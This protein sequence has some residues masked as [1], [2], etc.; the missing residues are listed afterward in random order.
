MSYLT[1]TTQDIQDVAKTLIYA[2]DKTTSRDIL[3]KMRADNYW[4]NQTEVA[5]ALRDLL[6]TDPSYVRTFQPDASVPTGGYFIYGL[7]SVI[8]T[9]ASAPVYPAK[10]KK[11]QTVGDYEARDK[12]DPNWTLVRYD[13]V[14]ENQAKHLFSEEY[15][16]AYTDVRVKKA[17]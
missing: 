12:N 8:K 15:G 10:V 14:T 17:V 3:E 7:A 6:A 13:N 2:T 5:A 1:A 9:T 16:V 11:V 4:I